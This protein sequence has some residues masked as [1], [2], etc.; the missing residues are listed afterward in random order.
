MTEVLL[1]SGIN[2]VRATVITDASFCP[3]TKSGGWA[4]WVKGDGGIVVKRSGALRLCENSTHA[5]VAAAANGC[6]LAAA[7]GAR[8]LL[9]QSDCMAVIH[10]LRGACKAPLL[11]ETWRLLM[12]M[13]VMQG[14]VV[15]GRHVKGHGRVKDARTWVNDWCDREARIYMEKGRGNARRR[16]H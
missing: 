16:P 1:P 3:N 12:A 7:S 13:P 2:T 6:W 9:L 11:L 10:I 5:E 8:E 4:A 14:V 15:T